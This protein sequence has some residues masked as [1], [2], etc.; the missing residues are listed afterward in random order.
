MQHQML[1]KG[2]CVKRWHTITNVQEQTVAAHSWGVAVIA[3]ELWPDSSAAFIHALLL[4]DIPEQVIGDVPAPVKWSNPELAAKVAKAEEDFWRDVKTEFPDLSKLERL[5]LKL[6]DMLELLWFCVEEERL[7]NRNF[8]E[9]FTRGVEYLQ[10][11]VL[12]D[13]STA[14]LNDLIA[15]EAEL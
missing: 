1:R 11:L 15:M 13:Q 12:D 10:D 4:H 7:G 8:K 9:V 6:A 3:L 14:M 2:G 5:K